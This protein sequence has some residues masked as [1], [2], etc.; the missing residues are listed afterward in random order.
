MSKDNFRLLLIVDTEEKNFLDAPYCIIILH[1]LLIHDIYLI[2]LKQRLG[3]C[4][5][6]ETK[7][8]Q[9]H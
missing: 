5:R 1:S 9:S 8:R 6:S 3:S 7:Q 4:S 2:I